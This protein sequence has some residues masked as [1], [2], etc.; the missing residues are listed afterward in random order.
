MLNDAHILVQGRIHDAIKS[1]VPSIKSTN[2]KKIARVGLNEGRIQYEDLKRLSKNV[3]RDKRLA[4][5]NFDDILIGATF[6]FPD[7]TSPNDPFIDRFYRRLTGMSSK[8]DGGFKDYSCIVN[9]VLTLLGSTAAVF[10][11][12]RFFF[13]LGM[14]SAMITS[15]ISALVFMVCE[16]YIMIKTE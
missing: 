3:A 8:E 16:V 13:G 14:H 11:I 15:A 6:I 9:L 2:L 7:Q 4:L 10:I 1:A 12:A 5:G